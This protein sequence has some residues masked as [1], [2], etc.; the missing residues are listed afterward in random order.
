MKRFSVII[1]PTAE[2]DIIDSFLWGCSEWGVD[3]AERWARRLRHEILD[4]LRL[5][6]L[7]FSIAPETDEIGTEFRQMISGRYRVLFYIKGNEVRVAHVR[8][9]FVGKEEEE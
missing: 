9:A 6:P 1:S 4:R 7:R 8:G 2:T 5:L 3:A